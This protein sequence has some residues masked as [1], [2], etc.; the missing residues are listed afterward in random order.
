MIARKNPNYPFLGNDETWKSYH[1]Y[2][3]QKLS[4]RSKEYNYKFIDVYY[5]YLSGKFSYVNVHIKDPYY[6]KEYFYNEYGI[7]LDFK[8]I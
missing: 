1:E 8:D 3:N 4:E 6:I 5:Q 7:D 2:F